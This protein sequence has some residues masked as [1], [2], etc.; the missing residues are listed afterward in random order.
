MARRDVVLRRRVRRRGVEHSRCNYVQCASAQALRRIRIVLIEGK[1]NNSSEKASVIE[2]KRPV[3]LLHAF[4]FRNFA[5][6]S[7]RLQG[8]VR[9]DARQE[10]PVRH[11]Q[12]SQAWRPPSLA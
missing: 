4:N 3:L 10:A 6:A 2:V 8:R 11:A 1:S 9:A 7:A 5:P 12:L